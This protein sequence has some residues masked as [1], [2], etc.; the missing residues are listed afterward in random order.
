MYTKPL[1]SFVFPFRCERITS[2]VFGT[3]DMTAFVVFDVSISKGIVGGR[4]T[5]DNI[6]QIGNLTHSRTTR[7]TRLVDGQ[8]HLFRRTV[9]LV[10]FYH[11]RRQF[12]HG[13]HINYVFTLLS[14]RTRKV[15]RNFRRHKCC[16]AS[17]ALV[18]RTQ[19][20]DSFLY[21]EAAIITCAC[22]YR[23]DFLISSLKN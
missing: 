9:S 1:G 6:R 3:T 8:K 13:F 23:E 14:M 17:L 19:K 15:I 20:I 4:Q 22:V 7:K 2:A 21:H 12:V 11:F 16:P 10:L 5:E 18:V